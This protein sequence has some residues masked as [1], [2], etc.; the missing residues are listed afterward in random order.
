VARSTLRYGTVPTLLTGWIKTRFW[1]TPPYKESSLIEENPTWTKSPL[2]GGEIVSKLQKLA[3]KIAKREGKKSQVK[4]GDVREVLKILADLE[5]ESLLKKSR[6]A[7][8]S[9]LDI[10]GEQVVKRYKKERPKE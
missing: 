1:W 10:I 5:F 8:A 9:P 7:V 4:I 2:R 3:S 6:R